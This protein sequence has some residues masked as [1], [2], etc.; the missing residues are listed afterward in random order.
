MTDITLGIKITADGKNAKTEITSVSS[1]LGKL[2]QSSGKA[3][4]GLKATSGAAGTAGRAFDTLGISAA[5]LGGFFTGVA[6]VGYTKALIDIGDRANVLASR[7]KLV[8]NSAQQF[9]AVQQALYAQAQNNGTAL[10]AQADLYAKLARATEGTGR[11]ARD[12]LTVTD[13]LAKQLRLSG[14]SA[15]TASAVMYQFG[16]MAGKA[17]VNGDEF[18]SIMEGAPTVMQGVAKA[19]GYTTGELINLAHAQKLTTRDFID[20]MVRMKEATDQQA[21]SMG[22]TFAQAWQRFS[23]SVFDATGALNNFLGVSKSAASVVNDIARAIDSVLGKTPTAEQAISDI[24]QAALKLYEAQ[25]EGSFLGAPNTAAI[26]EAKKALSDAQE[27]YAKANASARAVG[28]TLAEGFGKAKYEIADVGK[29]ADATMAAVLDAAKRYNVPGTFAQAIFMRETGWAGKNYQGLTSPAGAIGTM[30]LMPATAQR[31]GVDAK[32]A[33]Q[34]IEGGVKL[35]AQLLKKYGDDFKKAAAAYNAGE[36]AV[37]RYGGTPP[38]KETREYVA[39]VEDFLRKHPGGAELLNTQDQKGEI[40]QAK[41]ELNSFVETQ[42]S[43]AKAQETVAKSQ[44]ATE[45][46]ILDVRRNAFEAYTKQAASEM[47]GSDKVAYLQRA[48]QQEAALIQ[49][50]VAKKQEAIQKEKELSQAELAGINLRIAAAD[51]LQLT[52]SERISLT[53]QQ[54]QAQAELSSLTEQYNAVAVQ[55]AGELVQVQ[56]QVADAQIE[57]AKAIADAAQARTEYLAKLDAQIE[58]LK[59]GNKLLSDQAELHKLTAGMAADEAKQF[60]ALANSKKQQINE[61]EKAQKAQQDNEKAVADQVLRTGQY[62]EAMVRQAQN[63]ASGMAEAFG[64]TGAAIGQLIVGLAQYQDTMYNIQQRTDALLKA[65]REAGGGIDQ[66]MQIRAHAMNQE[67]AAQVNNYGN[68]TQAAQSFFDKG[69]SGYQAMEN[70]TKVFRAVELA[71]TLANYVQMATAGAAYTVQDIAQT[72]ARTTVKGTEAVVN[73]ASSGDPYSAFPRMAAMVAALAALG[74]AV[75]G[76]FSGGSTTSG[77]VSR[78]TKSN[79]TVFGDSSAQSNSLQNALELVAKN[80]STDLAYSAGMLRSLQNIESAMAGVTNSVIRNVAPA[81]V[82]GLGTKQ[83]ISWDPFA[84]FL[85]TTKA[86]TDWGIGAFPQALQKILA[87]GFEG[88]TFTDVTTSVKF[89]GMTLASSTKTMIGDMASETEKQFTLAFKSIADTV[90]EASQAFGTSSEDFN[91]MVETFV[92]KFDTTSLKGLKGEELEKAIQGQFSKIAD[93]IAAALNITG[94]EEFQKVGEGMFETLVRVSEGITRANAELDALGINAI[95]YSDITVKQGDVASEI[96]RQSIVAFE[97]LNSGIG[98]FIDQAVGSA[99]ELI[100]TYQDLLQSRDILKGLGLDFENLNRTMTDAAGGVSNFL[101]ALQSFRDNFYNQGEQLSTE[102]VS[103]ARE[104][105][106]LGLAMP[107]SKDGFRALAESIDTSTEAGAELFARLIKLSEAFATAS[108]AADELEKKYASY[109]DPFA[110]FK[111]RIQN[112]IDDFET[113]LSARLGGIEAKYQNQA[114]LAKQQVNSPLQAES[115]RLSGILGTRQAEVAAEYATIAQ[116]QSRITELQDLINRAMASG[117]AKLASYVRSWMGEIDYLNGA[118]A[119]LNADVA[120]KMRD[121]DAMNNQ[122]AELQKQIAQNSADIDA[123]QLSDKL[124]ELTQERARILREQGDAIVRTMQDIWD[125]IVGT[126][127]DAQRSL[128][129]Q[130][131]ELTGPRAIAKLAGQNQR[132]ALGD[133]NRYIKVGGTD[134]AK[135]VELVSRAQQAIMDRYNARLEILT[136]QL[137]RE[138]ARIERDIRKSYAPQRQEIRQDLRETERAINKQLRIDTRALNAD[139]RETTRAINQ[140]ANQAIREAERSGNQRI[141]AI[142]QAGQAAIEAYRAQVQARIDAITEAMDTA[143]QALEDVQQ[144][145]Q[146]ALSDAQDL[147]MESLQ[148]AQNKEQKILRKAQDATMKGLQDQL[149]AAQSLKSA[150]AQVADYARQLKTSD[151]SS[152]S[153]QDKLAEAASQYADLLQKAKTDPEAAGKVTGAAD[154]YLRLAE[155]FFGR[156]TQ[157]AAIFD[158]VQK[159][160]EQLGATA[161]DP[162]DPIQTAIEAL[163]ESQEA[164]MEALQKLQREESKALQ[165][166]FRDESRALSREQQDASDAL[167]KT[168]QDRIDKVNDHAQKIE[169]RM[170]R[171]T[172]R[173]VQAVERETQKTVNQI[174]NQADKQIAQAERQTQRQIDKLENAAQRQINQA[175]RQADRQMAKLEKEIDRLVRQATSGDSSPAIDE[176]KQATIAKLQDLDRILGNAK[177]QAAQHAREQIEHLRQLGVL[178]T[179]QLRQLNKIGRQLGAGDTDVPSFASGGVLKPGYATVAEKGIEPIWFDRGGRVLSNAEA[180]ATLSDGDKKIA[181]AI[182]ELKQE[183]MILTKAQV[184]ANSRIVPAVESTAAETAQARRD[185]KIRPTK[186]I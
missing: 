141:R 157:F 71:L 56:Q 61:I 135:T 111:D 45:A 129:Q 63:A 28:D 90:R 136:R 34:N 46:Q 153:P 161:T 181:E 159:Q 123:G 16:Q 127:E 53:N 65:N 105:N 164:E 25:K 87:S 115:S 69:T 67:L 152:L 116:A 142:E 82:S 24:Q 1:E 178:N 160:L 124:R 125:E 55:G 39:F 10:E 158:T 102:L 176:L 165:R 37:D 177:E 30:Q 54:R 151:I 120:A 186:V 73:Q 86:I 27:A 98:E 167:R 59:T 94:L 92:V 68:L 14:A 101:D 66:E 162:T 2:E 119:T 20:G 79:G 70:A 22:G 85:K 5:K 117:N 143:M 19:L 121:I 83:T 138:K 52:E 173:Q 58:A 140:A 137:E 91:R 109:T 154:T 60:E 21:A 179:R 48:A 81:Q 42:I 145:Q 150:L 122:I 77:T 72:E 146:D 132:E 180:K 44:L 76:G 11:S 17:V 4:N 33:M 31:L 35:L 29:T 51:R 175:E 182:A 38:Y 6:L 78:N 183:V 43:A 134:P 88:K 40:N 75:A 32:D 131:A 13:V 89:F 3:A 103:L 113:I 96:V 148:D 93:Q 144:A 97:G 174:Q 171:D 166:V 168:F 36:G 47:Q 110:D 99:E 95:K 100:Q 147:R 170:Q 128:R 172:D 9:A 18:V 49:Q 130:I 41:S 7:L 169:D 84:I 112:V 62:Y 15:A 185:A 8:T 114:S 12:L 139:L 118:I 126:I 57:E 108:D 107:T 104:F 106:N 163:Q 23:N 26:N 155:A 149:S 64:E 74:V 80:S 50:Q 184:A 156:G 133:L